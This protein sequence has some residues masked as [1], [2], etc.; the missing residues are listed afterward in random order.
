MDFGPRTPDPWPIPGK[1]P[2][3]SIEIDPAGNFPARIRFNLG[4]SQPGIFSKQGRV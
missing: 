4:G 1:M 3:R 2:Q